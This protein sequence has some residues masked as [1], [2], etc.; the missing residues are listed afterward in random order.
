MHIRE[1]G[2]VACDSVVTALLYKQGMLFVGYAN[3]LIKVCIM[4]GF[5]F[6]L[7]FSSLSSLP[8]AKDQ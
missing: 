8:W 1:V 7:T 3:K 5:L 6:I 4:R 2:S